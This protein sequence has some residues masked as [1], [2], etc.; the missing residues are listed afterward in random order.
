MYRG[1]RSSGAWTG[2]GGND[3]GICI[4]QVYGQTAEDSFQLKGGYVTLEDSPYQYHLKSYGPSSTI[5]VAD[6]NQ[7]MLKN[8]GT[9]WDFRLESK[10]VVYSSLDL[11]EV[12]PVL[13]FVAPS[14]PKTHPNITGGKEQAIDSHS[15]QKLREPNLF[16]SVDSLDRGSRLTTTPDVHDVFV[17]GIPNSPPSSPSLAPVIPVISEAHP[18]VPTSGSSVSPFVASTPSVVVSPAF[19]SSVTP[20]FLSVLFILSKM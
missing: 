2:E 19:G 8:I 10:F 15:Q 20:F 9:F 1:S 7:R 4:I 18:V 16:S 13:D 3:Q 12:F 6:S 17:L 11:T 5:G 14:F